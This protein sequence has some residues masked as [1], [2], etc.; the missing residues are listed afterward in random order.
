[1]VARLGRAGA[2]K[3]LLCEGPG[4]AAPALDATHGPALQAAVERVAPL[5]VLFPAGGAGMALGPALAARIGA[6]FAGAA[7]DM[8]RRPTP[9]GRSPTAWGG[10]SSGAGGAAALPIGAS[11]RWRSNGRWS[12]S[13]LPA[14]PRRRSAARRST[15]T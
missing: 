1:M 12:P 3:V 8:S 14:W 10:S 11:I 5:L 6:A 2:D 13:W 7:E 15:S 4:L 9:P